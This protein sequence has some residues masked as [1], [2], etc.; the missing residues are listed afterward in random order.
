M[1]GPPTRRLRA[2]LRKSK[3]QLR[4]VVSVMQA[5]NASE[6]MPKKEN[7]IDGLNT[8]DSHCDLCHSAG[9]MLQI[10]ARRPHETR[11]MLLP[12]VRGSSHVEARGGHST[13]NQPYLHR[14]RSSC[15][16]AP[17]AAAA[18]LPAPPA[19]GRRCCR[20]AFGSVAGRAACPA[21]PPALPAPPAF[22]GKIALLFCAST[23]PVRV[24]H[25]L[26]CRLR[27][28][29]SGTWLTGVC[30]WSF[31]TD[32]RMLRHR[33]K[34]KCGSPQKVLFQHELS[35]APQPSKA[36]DTLREEL[37]A[38]PFLD[39]VFALA[40]ERP[41]QKRVLD[42]STLT[43]PASLALGVPTGWGRGAASSPMVPRKRAMAACRQAQQ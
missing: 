3:M 9:Q 18:R 19:A 13:R 31:V 42:R 4:M 15:P 16:A 28:L 24:Q 6:A 10:V 34:E 37:K 22:R 11:V 29:Q 41:T 2:S 1:Q 14:R 32:A 40:F 5:G 23:E 20:Q 8:V 12:L 36:C 35:E 27:L 26:K 33:P 43:V 30:R 7:E 21:A 38:G 25:P 17:P 39:S